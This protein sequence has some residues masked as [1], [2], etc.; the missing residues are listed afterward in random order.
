MSETVRSADPGLLSVRFWV[1]FDPTVTFPKLTEAGLMLS[2]GVAAITVPLSATGDEITPSALVS[3]MLPVAAPTLFPFSQT[4][5]LALCP[6]LRLMGVVRFEVVN[7]LLE[8]AAWEIVTLA[9]PVFVIVALC[10]TFPPI[11]TFPKLKLEGATVNED[12]AV[13]PP[14]PLVEFAFTTPEQPLSALSETAALTS[15]KIAKI[16]WSG[17]RKYFLPDPLLHLPHRSPIWLGLPRLSRGRV[18]RA[19]FQKILAGCPI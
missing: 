10:E 15:S 2:C 17:S 16:P 11:V 3:V 1:P 4:R 14:P 6:A 13:P 19:R 12:G 8:M 18:S 5:K 7:S 9:F